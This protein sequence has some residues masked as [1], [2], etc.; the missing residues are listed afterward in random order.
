MPIRSPGEHLVEPIQTNLGEYP[1]R[2]DKHSSLKMASELDEK[3]EFLKTPFRIKAAIS[4]CE[5]NGAD[6]ITKD[7]GVIK[8]K[9]GWEMYVGGSNGTN[10]GSGV[11]LCL[12]GT[13]KEACEMIT[14]FIQYYRESANYLERIW[15]WISRVGLIH[16]R[17]AL[18]DE[19]IL[20]HLLKNF[21]A[22]RLRRKSYVVKSY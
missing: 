5:H 13:A 7:I 22:D 14:G 17:E 12:A 9:R 6:P 11:L 2:C 3:M 16:I 4:A 18:F 1:C 20:E 19:E 10:G 21:D 15:Q 8:V